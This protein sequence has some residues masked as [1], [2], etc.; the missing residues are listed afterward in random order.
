MLSSLQSDQMELDAQGTQRWPQ[1]GTLPS[2]PPQPSSPLNWGSG[3]AK[4][5]IL[6]LLPAVEASFLP[7]SPLPIYPFPPA[8]DS[9]QMPARG[10]LAKSG[11]GTAHQRLAAISRGPHVSNSGQP[12]L[13][14]ETLKQ[15]TTRPVIPVPSVCSPTVPEPCGPACL[16]PANVTDLQQPSTPPSHTS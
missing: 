16:A 13:Q 1:E 9:A 15:A 10:V 11:R 6:C 12:W 2:S 5:A 14:T 4:G 7:K 8:A 3:W